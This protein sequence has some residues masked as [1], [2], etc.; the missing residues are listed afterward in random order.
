MTP[1][2][3]PKELLNKIK[4]AARLQAQ[5]D[6]LWCVEEI[7]IGEAYLQQSLRA[8]HKVIEENNINAFHFIEK[9]SWDH[10]GE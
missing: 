4:E 9:Q 7:S 6:S 1:K 2:D 5:D 10:K 3:E 8:L